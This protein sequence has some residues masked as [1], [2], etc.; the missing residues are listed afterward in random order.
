MVKFCKT[1]C[2]V[3]PI[4][5]SANTLANAH[6]GHK[7]CPRATDTLLNLHSLLILFDNSYLQCLVGN[8]DIGSLNEK[9]NGHML[10]NYGL[11]GYHD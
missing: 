6:T 8:A 2:I 10:F 4:W 11:T 3:L 9:S 5:L 1:A 7:M